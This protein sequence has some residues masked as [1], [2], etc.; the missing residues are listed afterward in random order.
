MGS[1]LYICSCSC[2]SCSSF[3]QS[4]AASIDSCPFHTINA[5][6]HE[7]FVTAER[8]LVYSLICRCLF[9]GSL[10]YAQHRQLPLSDLC[11]QKSLTAKD[12]GRSAHTD[13]TTALRFGTVAD[14]AATIGV[15]SQ[16]GALDASRDFFVAALS[17]SLWLDYGLLCYRSRTA[18]NS[19]R[20]SLAW[21]L[22]A[23][24]GC[25]VK[26]KCCN[27]LHWIATSL[28]RSLKSLTKMVG[29]E[30]HQNAPGP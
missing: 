4:F 17:L 5:S 11:V 21:W 13:A 18:I 26:W 14:G 19:S 10:I 22:A 27:Y 8:W 29:S 1:L 30:A 24:I 6:Q 23:G 20:V 12:S 15:Y 16:I 25:S 2:S 7:R 9:L 3:H 28:E